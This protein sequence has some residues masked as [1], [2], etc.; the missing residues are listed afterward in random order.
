M[1]QSNSGSREVFSSGTAISRLALGVDFTKSWT[2]VPTARSIMADES[3]LRRR[4]SMFLLV[5]RLPKEEVKRS[6][7]NGWMGFGLWRLTV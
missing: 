7:C 5:I 1:V 2:A 4:D 3:L 6:F